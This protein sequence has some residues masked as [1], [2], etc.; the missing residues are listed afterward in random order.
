MFHFLVDSNAIASSAHSCTTQSFWKLSLLF[1]WWWIPHSGH[2]TCLA[3]SL[4]M[5]CVLQAFLFFLLIRHKVS[6]CCSAWPLTHTHALPS[7]VQVC[8]TMLLK[9][10][11]V[12]TWENSPASYQHIT[13][14]SCPSPFLVVVT[15]SY[16]PTRQSVSIC[17]FECAFMKERDR[18]M[19]THTWMHTRTEEADSYNIQYF[20]KKWHVLRSPNVYALSVTVHWENN[21][22]TI[23]GHSGWTKILPSKYIPF[24]LIRIHVGI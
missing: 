19:R 3:S 6:L 17:T 11:Y 7:G 10:F 16:C 12:E 20:R 9:T 22:H 14:I 21:H 18:N 8:T 13:L 15:L 24:F 1:L 23:L 5:N 2:C 4:P